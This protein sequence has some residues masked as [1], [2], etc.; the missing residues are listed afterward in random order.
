MAHLC[1]LQS[2]KLIEQLTAQ[3]G[4]EVS[5][6]AFAYLVHLTTPDKEYSKQNAKLEQNSVRSLTLPCLARWRRHGHDTSGEYLSQLLSLVYEQAAEYKGN[7]VQLRACTC[8]KHKG[9]H[10]QYNTVHNH[11]QKQLTLYM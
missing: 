9:N 5:L 10:V 3:H 11:E 7:C 1:I 8:T 4:I 6:D 2:L